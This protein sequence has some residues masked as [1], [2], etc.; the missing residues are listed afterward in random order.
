MRNGPS[1]AFPISSI[2]MAWVPR[3]RLFARY[4]CSLL[5]A[6]PFCTLWHDWPNTLY[7]TEMRKLDWTKP[8]FPS[9]PPCKKMDVGQE[10]ATVRVRSHEGNTSRGLGYASIPAN[11]S[12]LVWDLE[13]WY[14]LSTFGTLNSFPQVLQTILRPENA[15]MLTIL[16]AHSNLSQ[17]IWI[18]ADCNDFII[19]RTLFHH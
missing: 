18:L 1:L 11:S 4:R 2:L 6:E 3:V 7:Q 15:S 14:D 10:R 19:I 13:T 16:L 8:M 9:A 17:D 12:M 5:T